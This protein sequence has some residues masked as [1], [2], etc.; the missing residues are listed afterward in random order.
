[1]PVDF[2]FLKFDS[3][4]EKTSSDATLPHKITLRSLFSLFSGKAAQ[5]GYLAA[6][7]QGA[8]SL[9]NF[10]ATIILARSASP[11]ELG[12]YGVGFTALRL[13][14]SIQEGITIQPMNVIGAGMEEADFRRYATGTSL[15]QIGLA[16][17][18]SAV[19]A[20]GGWILTAAGNDV[21]GPTLF[22]LW[23]VFLWWQLQEYIRRMMYT[24][25]TVFNAVVNTV[26]A[27]VVRLVLMV[28]W[29]QQSR[30]NG[31]TSLNAIG[32]GSLAA[33]LPGLWFTRRY[34]GRSWLSLRQTWQ[35]NWDFGRWVLGGT[36]A[37]WV[38]VEFYPVLTAGM[39]SFAAAGAYRALQNL[40]API[41]LLLRAI[42]TFLT[43]RAARQFDQGGKTALNHTLRLTYLIAGIPI[44][45]V[46]GIAMLFPGQILH[47]LYG[48]TYVE[49]AGGVTLMAIFYILWFAYWPMQ[50][51]LKAAR[52]SRPIFIANL[53]AIVTM[54]TMGVWAIW[55]WGVFGTIAGQAL[56]S[57]VVGVILWA[58]WIKIRRKDV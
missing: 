5:E 54:F 4:T 14:R 40:V 10:L 32:W 43:P 15:L 50:T 44:L 51:A 22:A 56:N 34:W 39:I 58:S 30:L 31:I 55:R 57:L 53:A 49:Y 28:W 48:D 33:L 29:Q 25:G 20:A 42:D 47:L 52:F 8:I 7:D 1:M 24:R 45:S 19:V 11:T 6:V 36:I 2:S 3:T 38:A 21:A 18:C 37:N 26:L 23:F 13:A 27:N 41:H 9:S 17:L 16:L 12:V 35:R 46:L